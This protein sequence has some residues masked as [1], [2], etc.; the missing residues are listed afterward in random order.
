M[1]R[2]LLGF[3]PLANGPNSDPTIPHSASNLPWASLGTQEHHLGD[4]ALML[5]ASLWKFL[6]TNKDV[7]PVRLGEIEPF[8]INMD[9]VKEANVLIRPFSADGRGVKRRKAVCHSV[10]LGEVGEV[11]L[12]GIA[13]DKEDLF[14]LQ[15]TTHSLKRHSNLFGK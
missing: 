4:V 1:I 13:V 12:N 5:D 6:I 14:L 3:T 15:Q 10:L 2:G 11:G 7:T 8:L 9:P